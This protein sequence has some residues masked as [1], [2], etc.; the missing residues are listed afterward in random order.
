[1][2]RL[3]SQ[4]HLTFAYTPEGYISSMCEAK[5]R[6]TYWTYTLGGKIQSKT[7][8]DGSV[9]LYEY[10]SQGNLIRMGSR[11]F[12][13]DALG[14][15][16]QGSG[17]KRE[18]DPFGNI[19]KE[20]L[21]TGL[22]LESLYD[23]WDRPIQRILPDGSQIYYKYEGPFLKSV[24]RIDQKGSERYTHYYEKYDLKGNVILESSLFT[25]SYTYDKIGRKVYQENPYFEEALQY[26]LAGNLIQKGDNRFLYDDASQLISEEGK[27]NAAYDQ[28]YN[29]VQKNGEIIQI[30]ELNQ[31]KDLQYDIRGNLVKLGFIYDEFDQLI[32][33]DMEQ[34]VY[35]ALGR[36]LSSGPVS[37]FYIEDEEIG[38]FENGKIKELKILGHTGAIAIEINKKAYVPIVDIQNTIRKLVDWDKKEIVFVNSCDAF[39]RGLSEEIPYAYMGK[40]Y[41]PCSRLVYFG[42]RFYDPSLARWLTP[43]PLGAIDHSNLYQYVFNNPFKYYDPNGEFVL[44]IP[45]IFLGAELALPAITACITAI[46][47]SAAAGAVV[48]GGY[49]AIEVINKNTNVYA[50]DRPLPNNPD[51]KHIPDTDAPHTQLGTKQ[52]SKG[53]YPQAREFDENGNPVR[54]IDFTDH[55]RPEKHP[56]PHQHQHIEN[57]TGGTPKRSK[58]PKPVTGWKY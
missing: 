19:L 32:Q 36:R 1:M 24:S 18:L 20:E 50:P 58:N 10:N 55:S 5:K 28:H 41:D 4:D 53:K 23:D 7:K 34:H 12:R 13:Y 26:D 38:S 52:G 40:R 49:K 9:I 21:G 30:D 43:D 51:G 37:Y 29:C 54:D 31:Q 14:R 39:G 16:I 42:K 25:T 3:T 2:L 17:F 11:E 46:T 15:L 56:N 8:P 6:T 33:T 22:I 48:Y 57:K 27:Y 44:A 47:Y 35:D 45:L